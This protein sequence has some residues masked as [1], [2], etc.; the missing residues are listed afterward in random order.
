MIKLLV[1]VFNSLN[2]FLHNPKK[3]FVFCLGV[4]FVSLIV[5][6]TLFKI[7]RLTVDEKELDLRISKLELENYE[8]KAKIEKVSDPKFLEL[9]VRERLDWV[10]SDD[11]VFIFTDN[12]R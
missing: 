2:N 5:E 7:I 10:E 1:A 11:L 8:L 3:V 6:G 9:E 4:I 12:K